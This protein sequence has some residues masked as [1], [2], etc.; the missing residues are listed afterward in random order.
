MIQSDWWT[1]VKEIHNGRE[2][3]CAS[4]ILLLRRNPPYGLHTEQQARELA[5][6]LNKGE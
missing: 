4:Q 2:V 6:R 1:V 3:F 5:E